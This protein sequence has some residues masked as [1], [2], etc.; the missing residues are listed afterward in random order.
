ML[1]FQSTAAFVLA[2]RRSAPG[3]W[4]APFGHGLP[5]A[6]SGT[7]QNIAIRHVNIDG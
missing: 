2:P 7:V 1:P 6:A 3:R 5:H 4:H